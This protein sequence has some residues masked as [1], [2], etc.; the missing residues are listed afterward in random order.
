MNYHNLTRQ[1]NSKKT[2]KTPN[3]TRSLNRSN[4]DSKPKSYTESQSYLCKFSLQVTNEIQVVKH[5]DLNKFKT[6][7]C[8]RNC[9]NIK[10]CPYYHSSEDQRRSPEVV[11]YNPQVCHFGL[12]CLRKDRCPF[13]HNKYELN[14]H[15]LRYKKAYCRHLFDDKGCAYGP[16]C[17]SAHFDEELNIDL[18]HT[19]D[20]DDDFL[21]FKYKTEFCPFVKE[22]NLKKCVYA[23]SWEDY[24]RN[25]IL[26][27]YSNTPCPNIENE[28]EESFDG[29]CEEEND[30][31]YAHGT[32][33]VD[34]HPLN[35]K[36]KN[37]GMDKCEKVFCSYLHG[38]ETRRFLKISKMD[39]FYIFPYNR[40][41]PGKM[42]KTKSF[43]NAKSPNIVY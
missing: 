16:F 25:I 42:V 5:L 43:F 34:F 37:C 7:K 31:Q 36:K 13:T 28:D 10:Q 38:E 29:R 21:I 39:N 27:P 2:R 32:Y 30:C 12:N 6:T 14:Y 19:Y 9:D 35:Y 17:S 3:P 24:R 11:D 26:F 4:K 33:E 23:H 41:L 8:T 40:V 1:I 18:L 15:P 22:H 20:F